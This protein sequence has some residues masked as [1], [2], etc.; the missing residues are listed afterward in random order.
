MKTILVITHRP[1]LLNTVKVKMEK[2]AY[3]V[4]GLPNSREALRLV[5]D[6]KVDFVL[7]DV[8]TALAEGVSALNSL[9]GLNPAVPVVVTSLVKP[10]E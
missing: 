8:E 9:R 1:E 3:R 7:F 10:A 5:R 4:E 6:K 2:R